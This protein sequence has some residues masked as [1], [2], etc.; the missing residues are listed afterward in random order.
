MT[1]DDLLIYAKKFIH[2]DQAK[3]LLA[4][5]LNKNPLELLNYLDEKVN[6]DVVQEYKKRVEAVSTGYPIQYAMGYVNFYGN[7][8]FINE[9]VLIPR[10]E[11]EELVENTIKYIE[12][13]F[14]YPVNII[15]LGCGSGN[16]GLTLKQK[17]QNSEVDLIDISDKALDVCRKNAD[18][19]GLYVNI[20]KSDFF[21]NV[22]N[23][24][25]VIISNPPYIK[26]EEEIDDIVKNNE[27]ALALYGGEDGLDYYRVIFNDIK[28][29]LKEKFL[30]ALEIGY[31][32]QEQLVDLISN[33]LDKV[34]IDCKKDLSGKDRMIFIYNE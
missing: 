14:D 15:D 11:T 1:I 27:P 29:H 8:L 20:Y 6:E 23:K 31:T 25:D 22:D 7:K 3:L 32:E 16:I 34:K 10:F 9:D 2:K 5:L 13:I 24:Y 18:N 19:L 21:S 33:T 26:T 12:D 4:D 17:L 30:I 28:N